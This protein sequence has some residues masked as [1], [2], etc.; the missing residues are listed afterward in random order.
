MKLHWDFDGTVSNLKFD[1]G[2]MATFATLPSLINK[3]EGLSI[4][5]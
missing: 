3:Q 5:G 4:F 1:L 2:Q